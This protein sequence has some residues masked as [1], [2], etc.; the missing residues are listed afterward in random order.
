MSKLQLFILATILTFV[1][2]LIWHA[3]SP[4][5]NPLNW[6]MYEHQT[7]INEIRQGHFAFLTSQISDTFTVNS[8]PPFFHLVL[9]GLQVI[10]RLPPL[11]FWWLFEKVFFFCTVLASIWLGWIVTKD[12][13]A[14]FFSGMLGAFVFES[15][16][17]YTS[18]FLMPQTL[19]A[20]VFVFTLIRLLKRFDLE[21]SR[22]GRT[23]T[24]IFDFWQILLMVIMFVAHYIVGTVAILTLLGTFFLLRFDLFKGRTFTRIFSIVPLVVFPVICA[25][26]ML[27][28]D[29]TFDPFQ[30]SE[31]IH[32]NLNLA[33]KIEIVRQWYGLS[34]P[35]L[36]VLGVWGIMKKEKKVKKVEKVILGIGLF[37]IG[38]VLIPFP[39]VVKFYVLA[40]YVWHVV[41]A[42]GL[43]W[44]I[45]LLGSKYIKVAAATFVCTIFVLIFI[46]NQQGFKS[47]LKYN[48]LTTHTTL[49]DK[50]VA[51]FLQENYGNQE[52]V[53]L[54]SEP[55]TQGI[56]EALSGVNTQGGVY[57]TTET[58][59]I[60]DNIYP[61]HDVWFIRSSLYQVKDKLA[62]E[63]GDKIF[64]VLSGRFFAW[65]EKSEVQKMDTSF[66]IWQP[67]DL[68]FRDKEYINWLKKQED[69]SLVFEN[70][71]MA[72]FT[73]IRPQ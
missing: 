66:N 6:D 9:A 28:P 72:I 51:E 52:G 71:G 33:Q 19:C 16:M 67:Q 59:K 69:F 73:V 45:S 22:G 25:T 38:L 65:Q 70:E 4:Y 11:S 37:L 3:D 32:F 5:P 30:T 12:K 49:Y 42:I 56:L 2:L 1:T 41:F 29:L 46:N 57:A 40:R 47:I 50:L 31:S 35:I 10:T 54:I 34:F 7:L 55:A 58:R 63:H 23:S 39:Y 17:A 24:R 62:R 27:K 53:L 61:T 15:H 48:K 18:L 14:A 13:W 8:Y 43:S 21:R 44:V 60:V 20:L 36:G 68:T 26:L 64:L